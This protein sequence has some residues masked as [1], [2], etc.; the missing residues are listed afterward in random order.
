M[1][2]F[3]V[4][5][6]PI[7]DFPTEKELLDLPHDLYDAWCVQFFCDVLNSRKSVAQFFRVTPGHTGGIILLRRMIAEYEPV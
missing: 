2:L 6:Y 3:D 4:I 7:S 1:S 5:K